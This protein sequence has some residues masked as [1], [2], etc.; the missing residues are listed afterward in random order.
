MGGGSYSQDVAESLRS[1]QQDAFSYSAYTVTDQSGAARRAVHPAISPYKTRREVNNET[2]IVVALDVTRSRGDDTKLMYDKLPMLM[3]QIALQGYVKNPGISFAAIGDATSDGAPLQVGQFE[4]DNRLDEVLSR[5]WIEEGG[6]G[7]G[8]E[9]YELAAYYYSRTNCVRLAKGIGKKGYFFFV[10]DEGFYPKVDKEQVLRV[11]GEELPED[12]PASE[13]FRRLH[14]KFHVYLLYPK[15]SFAERKA[16]IDAEIR[17]RVKAAG[18]MYE[19]V[20]IRASLIWNNRNDLDLHVMTPTQEHIYYGAK[21]SACGGW[22]D[23]DMNVRGETEK[24]VENVRWQKGTAPKGRY[25]IYVQ[26]YSFKEPK[27]D[28]TPFK[29]E[30][31]IDGEIQHFS[32]IV[33]P[34]GQT[35][36]AS[37]VPVFQFEYDPEAKRRKA[38]AE[39]DKDPKKDPQKDQYAQYADDVILAQ[40]ATVLGQDHILRIEDPKSIIDV[41]LGALALA[42]GARDLDGYL[43]DMRQREAGEARIAQVQETLSVLTRPLTA[44]VVE[45]DVPAG[46][47]GRSGRSKRL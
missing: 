8:Q 38:A 22:L 19:G 12:L 34:K 16:D 21:R 44:G 15:K 10:G 3:G 32:G 4:G 41:L 47:G 23:V 27:H 33:S 5:I 13:A 46:G 40:W 9:S 24:P 7:T 14:E 28:P 29:V 42:E 11:L 25:Q 45:G 39:S 30:V 31:E 43:A 1:T 6:G 26:N 2:P 18:G 20:D 17:Q 37:N 35:G 36:P